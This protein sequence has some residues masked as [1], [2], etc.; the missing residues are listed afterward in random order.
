[1]TG[2]KAEGRAPAVPKMPRA[3]RARE[4]V[5]INKAELGARMIIEAME[6]AQD[7]YRR[8]FAFGVAV[9]ALA[10]AVRKT[11]ARDMLR[12]AVLIEMKAVAPPGRIDAAEVA[13]AEA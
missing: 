9:S 2:G 1:M 8:S 4:R 6:D 13:K 7:E 12:T 3:E 11:G 5:M 10:G